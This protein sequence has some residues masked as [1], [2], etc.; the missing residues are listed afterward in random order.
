M[1]LIEEVQNVIEHC[2]KYASD[3]LIE[4]C[5]AYPFGA[6]I[7]TIGNVHPMEVEVD[8]NNMP[9]V[10]QVI[11]QLKEY[12][13][14]EMQVEKMRGYVLCY[15]VSYEMEEGGQSLDAIA[16]DVTHVE[17]SPPLFYLPFNAGEEMSVGELFAVERS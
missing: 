8:K 7:D 17:E 4:T 15:E 12:A 2:R 11:S 6:F 16:I 1:E 5:E 9:N 13:D 3:L 14:A 10:G